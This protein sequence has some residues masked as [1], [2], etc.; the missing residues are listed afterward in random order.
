MVVHI[1]ITTYIALSILVLRING[2]IYSLIGSIIHYP[3]FVYLLDGKILIVT[4]CSKNS[5][6][7]AHIVGSIQNCYSSRNKCHS[8]G[9]KY[10]HHFQRSHYRLPSFQ[11]LL[12]ECVIWWPVVLFRLFFHCSGGYFRS[13][14]DRYCGQQG[15]VMTLIA[16]QHRLFYIIYEKRPNRKK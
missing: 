4:Q 2:T 3:R 1:L 13:F 14:K 11:F 16:S 10:S 12:S 5:S 6:K 15:P 8:D 7:V 9:D